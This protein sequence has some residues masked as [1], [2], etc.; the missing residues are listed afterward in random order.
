VKFEIAT[1]VA[2]GIDCIG[3][4]KSNYHILTTMITGLVEIYPTTFTID[5]GKALN[6]NLEI[7]IKKN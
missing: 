3:S 4:Y 5:S 6:L 2:I 7:F 1:L